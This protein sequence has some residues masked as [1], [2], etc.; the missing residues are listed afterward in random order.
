M[1]R[2]DGFARIPDTRAVE[3]L[4]AVAALHAGSRTTFNVIDKVRL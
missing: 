1:A 2:Q 4:N 3:L